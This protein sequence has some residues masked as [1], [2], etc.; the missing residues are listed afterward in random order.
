MG[1]ERAS[2]ELLAAVQRHGRTIQIVTEGAEEL[3]YLN[4]IGAEANVGGET[5]SHILLRANPSKAAVLEEFLHGTQFRLG[6]VQRLGVQGAETHVKSF[7]IRHS[8]MLGLGE[9]DV[10]ALRQLM[11]VGL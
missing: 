5:M 7:M 11:E 4:Y 6:I 1:V 9:A 10:A 3:R 2:P 8:R